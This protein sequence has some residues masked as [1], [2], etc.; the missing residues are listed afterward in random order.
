MRHLFVFLAG[1]V[2][3]LSM[4]TFGLSREVHSFDITDPW[5]RCLSAMESAHIPGDMWECY[6][7]GTGQ[8]RR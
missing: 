1:V 5:E 2:V 7:P 6:E 8:G 4:A 3:G